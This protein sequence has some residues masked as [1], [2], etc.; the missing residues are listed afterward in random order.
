MAYKNP[1]CPQKV[2]WFCHQ[3]ISVACIRNNYYK[4]LKSKKIIWKDVP[5]EFF[6]YILRNANITQST[7]NYFQIDILLR[8]L[9]LMEWF[10]VRAKYAL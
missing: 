6:F 1:C 4:K 9:F 2:K 5:A 8:N 7:R 10:E 3:L